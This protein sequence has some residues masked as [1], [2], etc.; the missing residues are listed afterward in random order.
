MQQFK[1]PSSRVLD[2][3]AVYGGK[4]GGRAE[5]PGNAQSLELLIPGTSD[6]RPRS[7][8]HGSPTP[9]DVKHS[10]LTVDLGL[11]GSEP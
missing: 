10:Q 4:P 8:K 7:V 5:L 9:K 6:S 2:Y 3:T 11:I 1:W